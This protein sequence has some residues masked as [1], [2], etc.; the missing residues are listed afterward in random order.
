[1]KNLNMRMK[2][3]ILGIVVGI[4]PMILVGVMSFASAS[5]ELEDAVLKTNTVY[6]TLTKEQLTSF[7]AERQNDGKVIAGSDSITVSMEIASNKSSAN[8]QKKA[9]LY[10]MGKHLSTVVEEYGYTEIF[11]T[12][13]EGVVVYAAKMKDSL[14][15]VSFA[16]REYIKSALN[17]E[18]K[19]SKPFYTEVVDD[20]IMALGTPIY[21]S[22]YRK[23]IGTLVIVVDQPMLNKIVHKGIE[24]LG[25]SGDS[26]LVTADG[27]LITETRLGEYAEDAALKK[28]IDTEATRL[29]GS[30]IVNGNIEFEHIGSYKDYLGN[31]V[32]GFMGVIQ[33]GDQHMGLIIEVDDEEAFSGLIHLR[34]ITIGIIIFF[35]ILTL[36]TLYFFSKTITTPLTAV[37]KNA[38][39]LAD[40]DLTK[41]VE[42]KYLT[43]NDEMGTIAKAVQKVI[44]N[45]RDL[46]GEVA[47]N[48]EQVASSAEELTATSQ[49]AATGTEEV[50]GTINEIAKGASNQA[51]HTATGS[52][53]L[54]D[55]SQLI[56]KDREYIGDMNTAT[57]EVSN[58]VGEGL[59][60]SDEL[61]T[62]TKA[63]GEA[64][65]IVFESIVKTNES[66]VK[67]GEASN[68]IA[69]IAE[70][71][72]LL[73]LNAAI[74]AA[75]AGEAG[76]GFSV[77]A[78]EIRKLAEQSTQSTKSIDEIIATLKN[79]ADV[80][81]K[82]MEEASGFVK[83]QE[84]SVK[85]T[86]AKY[87]EIDKATKGAES[88][89]EILTKASTIMEERKEEVQIVIE[90]LSAVA[91][92]NAASTQEVS[93]TMEEQTASMEEITHAS[94][95][96]SELSTALQRL[97]EQFK[98]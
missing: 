5:N 74:E 15:G 51:D 10:R 25:E 49:Q 71:T 95:G 56:E 58:L 41:D 63:N 14:E 39:R 85:R 77:V 40:Y 45:L 52:E 38:S 80:A 30:E 33:V 98:L 7:F 8:T 53:K 35:V 24:K 65:D 81:V 18:Q 32:Y 91:E 17:G 69:A 55:L 21:N 37:V 82:K 68:V 36:I 66:S 19:W 70:Q 46:L 92:Q 76:K 22:D 72:N 61:A 93:A 60:I 2:L 73:A 48:A 96:L 84:E 27:L 43:R 47:K 86:V 28:T 88:V 89:V 1:M 26:Y 4:F 62:K 31:K 87:R 44:V 3:I 50:A 13:T 23:I 20:N 34:F 9:A 12:D 6:A 16:E 54:Y 11:V 64:V 97:I 29:L 42:Q 94:E 79:D 83:A 59:T 75:R 67:I 78:E 90:N 57:R